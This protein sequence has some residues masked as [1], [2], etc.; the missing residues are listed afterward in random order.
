MRDVLY[1]QMLQNP[2]VTWFMNSSLNYVIFYEQPCTWL[3]NSPLTQNVISCI[4]WKSGTP[5]QPVMTSHT[6]SRRTGPTVKFEFTYVVSFFQ[7]YMKRQA[8]TT[9]GL[10]ISPLIRVQNQNMAIHSKFRIFVPFL[11]WESLQTRFLANCGKMVH[12]IE[13]NKG[14]E[15]YRYGSVHVNA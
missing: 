3:M 2:S 14:M 15:F 10:L 5:Y 12:P 8:C 7:K 4:L 1:E 13:K 9:T 6:L 11:W